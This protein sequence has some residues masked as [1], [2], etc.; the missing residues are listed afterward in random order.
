MK[1]NKKRRLIAIILALCL[2]IG[3]MPAKSVYAEGETEVASSTDAAAKTDDIEKAEPDGETNDTN[4]SKEDEINSAPLLSLG[5]G[6][7]DTSGMV[8]VQFDN[9]TSISEAAKTVTFNVDNSSYVF[10]VRY[11]ASLSNDVVWKNNGLY[12]NPDKLFNVS[13]VVTNEFRDNCAIRVILASGNQ[14]LSIN[15]DNECNLGGLGLSAGNSIHFEPYP[16]RNNSQGSGNVEA[17]INLMGVDGTWTGEPMVRDNYDTMDDETGIASVPYNKYAYVVSVGINEGN[18]TE[19][20]RQYDKNADISTYKN[21]TVFFDRSTDEN[22]DPTNK[23]SI[24]FSTNWGNRIETIEINGTSYPVPLDYSNRNAWLNSIR[25][26]NVSFTIDNVPE[27]AP[28]TSGDN[29]NKEV[30]NISIKVRPITPEECFIGNFLWNDDDNP[31]DDQCIPHSRLKLLSVTYNDGTGEYTKTIDELKD[32]NGN[33]L[34]PFLHYNEHKEEGTG[35]MCGEMVV[36]EGSWVTM[37]IEPEYGYQV[38]A[39]K[40]SGDDVRT[41]TESSIFSFRVGRGN[42]HIG[43]QVEETENDAKIS[44]DGVDAAMIEL[45]DGV[46]DAGT[47]RLYIDT[48]ELDDEKQDAF[49]RVADENGLSLEDAFE[50]SLDQV[51]FKG[52]GSTDDVWSFEMNDLENPGLIYLLLPSSYLGKKVSVVHNIHNG[53]DFEVIEAEVIP[54]SELAPG[55]EGAM[56]IFPADSFSTFALALSEDTTDED[57]TEETP[58]DDSSD[59]SASK[60]DKGNK[61]NQSAGTTDKKTADDTP[62]NIIV[63]LM[64]ISLSGIIYCCTKK[65][66]LMRN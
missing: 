15:G 10:E 60:S 26:Q 28:D 65:H 61:K 3:S 25:S 45:D 64:I 14:D 18:R 12:I 50:I 44:A 36:P 52:T 63:I 27:A 30:Y 42:F 53:D 54:A 46:I 11:D 62:V 41:A 23:V 32:E 13:F 38:K 6:E 16:S 9:M 51:F 43:A 19:Y 55:M 22:G 5:E 4:N 37:K 29:E 7:P 40:L 24:E 21:Q 49:M 31:N 56:V 17:V 57:I 59:K 39:F 34:Y 20:M 2:V 33:D 1:R 48:P 58:N 35:I 47:A 66:Y 8:F